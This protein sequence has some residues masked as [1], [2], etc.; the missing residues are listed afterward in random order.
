MAGRELDAE[1]RQDAV[2]ALVVERQVLGVALDPVDDD[3]MPGGAVA[4]RVEQLGREVEPDDLRSGC[5]G[6]DG[7]VAGAGRDVE[8]GRPGASSTRVRRSRGGA[9]SISSATA[10]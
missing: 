10:A 3:V 2:E 8:D 1:R 4:R 7:D 6:A 5:G 9:S